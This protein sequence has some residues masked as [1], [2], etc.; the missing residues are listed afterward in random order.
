M[1]GL[2][3]IAAGVGI[4]AGFFP[5]MNRV[6]YEVS[7][8]IGQPTVIGGLGWSLEAPVIGWWPVQL[9][10]TVMGFGAAKLLAV[11]E[12]NQAVAQGGRLPF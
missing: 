3:K 4:L 10:L 2:L 5:G 9:A 1:N 7:A 6:L 11:R 12:A 8:M